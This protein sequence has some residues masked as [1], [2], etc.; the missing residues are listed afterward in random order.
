MD[1]L[2]NLGGVYQLVNFNEVLGTVSVYFVH[3]KTTVLI[4]VP[5]VND[6][7]ISGNDLDNYI[8]SWLPVTVE[9]K[10]YR[11]TINNPEVIARLITPYNKIPAS[12]DYLRRKAMER[13][14][15]ALQSCDWTQL[16]DVQEVMPIEEKRRWKKFRQELR[17]I[18]QQPSYPVNITWPQRPYMMGIV[19]YD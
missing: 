16:T 11:K 10:D 5:V 19:I 17:D 18:T 1:Q 4:D 7:Y 13:R 2:P 8:M 14:S 15:V 9:T 3:Q 6:M 12:E